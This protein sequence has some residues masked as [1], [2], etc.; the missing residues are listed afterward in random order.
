MAPRD[1]DEKPQ[2]TARR[3]SAQFIRGLLLAAVATAGPGIAGGC[4]T[5]LYGTEEY[6]IPP[7]DVAETTDATD[8]AAEDAGAEEDAA[9]EAPEATWDYGVPDGR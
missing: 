7:Y 8:D 4:G 5:P 3:C 9:T 1:R 6:G 2:P